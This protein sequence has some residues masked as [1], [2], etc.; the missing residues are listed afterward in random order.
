[1]YK[2]SL[3]D[4]KFKDFRYTPWTTFGTGGIAALIAY[5]RA[6][7]RGDSLGKRVG[8]ALKWGA[9]VGALGYLGG[10]AIDHLYWR[11][12][13]FADVIQKYNKSGIRSE[14][15]LRTAFNTLGWIATPRW[16]DLI[17]VSPFKASDFIPMA[18]GALNNGAAPPMPVSPDGG[19]MPD[20]SG[21]PDFSGMPDLSGMLFPVG[22]PEDLWPKVN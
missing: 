8:S 20:L 12:K 10:Q 5:L 22:R 9:G 2:Q 16:Y 4:P 3:L 1:M 7:R 13:N 15:D 21:T 18:Q 19:A 11:P 6:K 17:R 14:D